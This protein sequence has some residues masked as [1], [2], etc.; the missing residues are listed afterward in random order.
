MQAGPDVCCALPLKINI[1][2]LIKSIK[3]V[4]RPSLSLAMPF[5]DGCQIEA[6]YGSVKTAWLSDLFS[7]AV[8]IA[9]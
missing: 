3:A 9:M 6:T 1:T 8:C 7:H 5:H 4:S 2:T